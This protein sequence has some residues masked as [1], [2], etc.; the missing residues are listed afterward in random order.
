MDYIIFHLCFAAPQMSTRE[1]SA[2]T[3]RAKNMHEAHLRSMGLGQFTPS[4]NG[5]HNPPDDE[6]NKDDDFL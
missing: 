6:Q 3:R 4:N 2:R 1:M 5:S